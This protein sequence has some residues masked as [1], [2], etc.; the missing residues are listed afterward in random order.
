M[1]GAVG[2]QAE[3]HVAAGADFQC[4]ATPRQL[5]DQRRVLDRAHTMADAGHRQ[6]ADSGPDALRPHHLAGMH[7]AAQAV[8]VGEPIGR[9]E[10]GRGE[11]GLVAAHAE[12]HDIGMRLG[13]QLLRQRQ[14]PVRPE[15]AD[16]DADDTA[17][18]PE[19]A[20]CPVDRIDQRPQ[21]GG[22]GNA[23]HLRPLGRAEHLDI[24]RP[25]GCRA[26]KVG[27]EDIA[28]VARLA[29]HTADPV[30][31]VEEAQ[32]V[33]PDI[34][35]IGAEQIGR[36]LEAIACRKLARQLGR[37]GTFEVAVKFGL[38]NHVNPR[39][40]RSGRCSQLSRSYDAQPSIRCSV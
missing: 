2:I 8:L 5:L 7:G 37:D 33:A 17:L 1:R 14:R 39:S 32:E 36:Q 35:A 21:P 20:A 26:L 10:V 23:Q 28:E 3:G 27:I 4:N 38:G 25:L 18:D 9:R 15:M 30:V 40:G 29:Q 22:I 34:M 11:L 6:V 24:D 31:G 16:A 12:R 19:V 13:H